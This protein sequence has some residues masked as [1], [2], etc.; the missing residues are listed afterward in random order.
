[1]SSPSNPRVSLLSIDDLKQELAGL[2]ANSFVSLTDA[3]LRE[4]IRWI[5]EGFTLNAPT[6]EAGLAIYRAVK[7]SQRPSHHVRVSY[8]QPSLVKTNRRLRAGV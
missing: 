5:H 2:E 4:K 8:P 6:F 3:E 1:M 7:V